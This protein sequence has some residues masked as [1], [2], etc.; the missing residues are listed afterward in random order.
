[1]YPYNSTTSPCDY[2]VDQCLE[3]KICGQ[4]RTEKHAEVVSQ[5]ASLS[6]PSD[7][8]QTSSIMSPKR[9]YGP[10]NKLRIQL[11]PT[12]VTD[13]YVSRYIARIP[14]PQRSIDT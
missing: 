5:Q 11:D 10:M 13:G 14:Q 6:N 9:D 3:K 4:K 8:A 12:K 7:T 1:M 2:S